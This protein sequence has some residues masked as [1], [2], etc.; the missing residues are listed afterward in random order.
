MSISNES[1][2]AGGSEGMGGDRGTPEAVSRDAGQLGQDVKA[3]AADKAAQLRD[4]ATQYY[5]QGRDQA[6]QYYEQ[7]RQAVQE[8]EQNLEEYIREKPLQSVL[9][10]AGVGALLG[11]LLKK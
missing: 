9:I 7:G 11:I 8:Y 6:Q 1:G 4:Q 3:L 2:G 5:Q 10:A